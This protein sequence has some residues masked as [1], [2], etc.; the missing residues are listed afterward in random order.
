MSDRRLEWVSKNRTRRDRTRRA[1]DLVGAVVQSGRRPNDEVLHCMAEALAAC[2]DEEFRE[3]C[4]V[5]DFRGGLLRIHVDAPTL[6]STMRV[7][8]QTKIL[9]AIKPLRPPIAL[10]D[11]YF[12]FGRDGAP[13]LAGRVNQPNVCEPSL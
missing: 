7:R 3:H 10:R 4:R 9:A 6:V 8:W 5:A 11:V 2:A 1:G 12:A 13:V